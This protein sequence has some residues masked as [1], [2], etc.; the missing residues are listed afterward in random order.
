LE[1]DLAKK[2]AQRPDPQEL[3]KEHILQGISSYN[4][5]YVPANEDPTVEPKE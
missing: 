5:T 3:I 2:L 1:D 4:V